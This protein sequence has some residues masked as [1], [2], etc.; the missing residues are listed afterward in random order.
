MYVQ[1]VCLNQMKM[2]FYALYDVELIAFSDHC[3]IFT[4]LNTTII[5]CS[6]ESHLTHLKWF[7]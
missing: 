6:I 2:V 4:K 5:A 1:Q 7:E 3:E